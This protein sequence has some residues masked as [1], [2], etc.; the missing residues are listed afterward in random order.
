MID[1]EPV[2]GSAS[3]KA[4]VCIFKLNDRPRPD[5]PCLDM[6]DYM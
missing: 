2:E 3:D 4:V 6:L 1:V 5:D